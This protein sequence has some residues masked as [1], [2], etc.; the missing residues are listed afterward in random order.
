MKKI[1]QSF[2]RW[3]VAVGL[4]PTFRQNKTWTSDEREDSPLLEGFEFQSKEGLKFG[5]S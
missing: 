5:M 2:A 4:F 1:M 3:Y